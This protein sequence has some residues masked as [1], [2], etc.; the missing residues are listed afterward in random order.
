[1]GK[2][3][4]DFFY[5][6]DRRVFYLRVKTETEGRLPENFISF[7]MNKP[8]WG[9]LKKRYPRETWL[10]ELSSKTFYKQDDK[11]KVVD[12]IKKYNEEISQ[13]ET[14]RWYKVKDSGIVDADEPDLKKVR[15]EEDCNYQ[16]EMSPGAI[17]DFVETLRT[18][19]KVSYA[20]FQCPKCGKKQYQIVKNRRVRCSGEECRSNGDLRIDVKSDGVTKVFGSEDREQNKANAVDYLLRWSG[21]SDP[22]VAEPKKYAPF[23][24][25]RTT[26]RVSAADSNSLHRKLYEAF[27]VDEVFVEDGERIVFKPAYKNYAESL[28]SFGVSAARR[29]C[30]VK[31]AE[32]EINSQENSLRSKE[33]AFYW[34]FLKY[35]LP[36][37]KR[38]VWK[39]DGQIVSFKDKRQF[40]EDFLTAKDDRK[41]KLFGVFEAVSS[42]GLSNGFFAGYDGSPIDL[43]RLI[44]DETK[45]FVYATQDRFVDF[46][47][48][49][50][51]DLH[52]Y[53]GSVADRN[54]FLE[55]IRG[56]R[57][58]WESIKGSFDDYSDGY[59]DSSDP[60]YY[61]R[62]CYF[63]YAILA[64]KELCYKGVGLRNSVEGFKYV[65][66]TVCRAYM[67]R[68]TGLY[69]QLKE[70]LGIKAMWDQDR[71]AGLR[72]AESRL[73][74][75]AQEAVLTFDK[76]RDA[77]TNDPGDDPSVSL[78]LICADT[79]GKA[80][81]NLKFRYG[82]KLATLSEHVKGL[83]KGDSKTVAN[84]MARFYYDHD[85]TAVART[86]FDRTVEGGFKGFIEKQEKAFQAI[87]DAQ[88]KWSE[89]LDKLVKDTMSAEIK[90]TRQAAVRVP[91]PP[92]AT[93]SDVPKQNDK[94]KREIN[95]DEWS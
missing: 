36:D 3:K 15:M 76:L 39:I 71:F 37:E 28:Q 29:R 32:S 44:Y 5:D 78:Y 68:D 23:Y 53:D 59:Y 90:G 48:S 11:D 38:L 67:N 33:K 47:F 54:S 55:S 88:E 61:D 30:F 41:R 10:N 91:P 40:A 75:G 16:G 46:G 20:V 21:E 77:V 22:A 56:K 65:K 2:Q 34:F 13:S 50:I 73:T 26:Y 31:G 18:N 7:N 93:R 25:G 72:A 81:K 4:I 24:Y 57:A 85:V 82:D 14:T 35:R 84:D 94:T 87:V 49:F 51:E 6:D 89:D 95:E 58:F 60:T 43:S 64:K 52:L 86:V 62:L 70:L 45:R 17:I 79:S 27:D 74:G 8:N 80:V 92:A 66:D 1:M 63:R 12:L 9:V 83:L 42:L 69:L 19:K